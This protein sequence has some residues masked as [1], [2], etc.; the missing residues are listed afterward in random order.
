MR[1]IPAI[2]IDTPK[3][4]QG[5]PAEHGDARA[6]QGVAIVGMDCRFAGAATSPNGLWQMLVGGEL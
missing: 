3:S 5:V 4:E 6:G 1:G 2:S